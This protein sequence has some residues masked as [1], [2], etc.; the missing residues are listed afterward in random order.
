MRAAHTPNA[1]PLSRSQWWALV[2][3]TV[4]ELGWGLRAVSREVDHWRARAEVIRDP[5][6]QR[7]ALHALDAKRGHADGAAL[8]WTLSDRRDP[9]LLRMLV[10]YELLQDFLDSTTEHGAS[11]GPRNGSHLYLA[12][13][14]AL[15]IDRPLSDYYLHDRGRDDGGYLAALVAACREGCRGLPGYEAVRPLLV[16]EAQRAD[17]LLLN[18]D[19]CP[20]TRD[21]ALYAWAARQAPGEP[22][23]HWYELT[24][25]AS[26]WITTHALLALAAQPTATSA[27]AQAMYGAYF[28]WLALTLTLLDSYADEA[29]DAA[30]GNH[31]YLIHF[32]SRQAAV[33]RLCECIRRAAHSVRSLPDGER[34]AV[35][36]GCMIALYL[37][38]DSVRTPELRDATARV[39][40]AGGTLPKLLLPVL[41]TWR[42]CNGQRRTT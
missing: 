34:H 2:A 10:R 36:L 42:V 20:T 35:L 19:S 6:L 31:N 32:E 18:H 9:A 38:K 16:R 13:T 12:L 29:E 28:P 39:V 14:D 8:F 26:G 23:L 15:D 3:A 5:E 11:L 33:Q 24:A 30:A 22:E 27:D 37:S 17:V 21:R 7:D 1:L 40:A 25:A 41:R 4:R